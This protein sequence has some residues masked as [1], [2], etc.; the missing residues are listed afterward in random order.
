MSKLD[1]L[2]DF[3]PDEIISY[4]NRKEWYTVTSYN[5]SIIV[6]SRNNFSIKTNSGIEINCSNPTSRPICFKFN[7]QENQIK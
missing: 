6:D 5:K 7:I 2:N 1:I 3:T 4:F